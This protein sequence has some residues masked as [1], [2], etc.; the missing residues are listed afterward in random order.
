MINDPLP[1]V[2]AGYI[3]DFAECDFT[4]SAI[5][6]VAGGGV[7]VFA[8]RVAQVGEYLQDGDV[9]FLTGVGGN[10]LW[11]APANGTIDIAGVTWWGMSG[12]VERGY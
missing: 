1:W 9:L 5:E 10:I 11:T 2:G 12:S 6:K 7:H 8:G 4:V 3:C